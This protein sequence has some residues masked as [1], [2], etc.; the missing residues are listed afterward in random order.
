MAIND[1]L[2]IHNC[3]MD[4]VNVD[5]WRREGCLRKCNAWSNVLLP[6]S[7]KRRKQWKALP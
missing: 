2:F 5:G 6:R 3:D 4:E 7:W 1:V